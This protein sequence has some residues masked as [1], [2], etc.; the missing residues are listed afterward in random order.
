M[1]DE[2]IKMK[3]QW[4][5][6]LLA[7]S[8]RTEALFQR[9]RSPLLLLNDPGRIDRP[10]DNRSP[11]VIRVEE[12]DPLLLILSSIPESLFASRQKKK[13]ALWER[14][15]IESRARLSDSSPVPNRGRQRWSSRKKVIDL[16]EEFIPIGVKGQEG[17]VE[18][19]LQ[20]TIRAIH[21]A[22]GQGI[23]H[24]I[25]ATDM[26][27]G[28]RAGFQP[29]SVKTGDEKVFLSCSDGVLPGKACFDQGFLI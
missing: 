18:V 8:G 11:P 3:P 28:S 5:A 6:S 17:I 15:K 1:V 24:M 7:F 29:S 14:G 19:S 27:R 4:I 20:D 23:D 2:R 25:S 26:K 21:R 13:Q 10:G 9:C 16:L 12:G 22:V